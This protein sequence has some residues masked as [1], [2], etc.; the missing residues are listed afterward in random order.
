MRRVG[1]CFGR[2]GSCCRHQLHWWLQRFGGKGYTLG[3]QRLIAS[4]PEVLAQTE[5]VCSSVNVASSRVGIN[6]DA[7]RVMGGIVKE[8]AELTQDK[9]GAGCAKLVVFANVP[10]DNPF[11]AGAMHGV[12]Q[13]ELVINIGV[14]G[15]GVVLD[16]VRKQRSRD[17]GVLAEAIKRTA[18]KIR[19]SVNWSV[20]KHHSAWA[21]N[22]AWSISRWRRRRRLVTA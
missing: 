15:P 1:T 6:M 11:M 19:R 17:L 9:N 21:Y 5:A 8:T 10:E 13:P 18:F 7:I 20:R 12:G 2:V 16:T 22:S 4:I 14:S 3:D